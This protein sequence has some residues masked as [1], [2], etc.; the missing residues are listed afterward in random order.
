MIERRSALLT[1]VRKIQPAAVRQVL[2]QATVHGVVQKDERWVQRDLA[3][4]R[5]ERVLP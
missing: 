4:M 2:Y 5:R 3:D 1:I